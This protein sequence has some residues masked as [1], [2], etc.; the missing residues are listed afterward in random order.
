LTLRPKFPAAPSFSSHLN[1]FAMS[2]WLANTVF[3]TFDTLSTFVSPQR[4]R[5]ARP[6]AKPTTPQK[7]RAVEQGGRS[8][9]TKTARYDEDVYRSSP[10]GGAKLA[11][12]N[13]DVYHN[14]PFGSAGQER[15]DS[16][17]RGPKTPAEKGKLLIGQIGSVAEQQGAAS[18]PGKV[19][20]RRSVPSNAT[21]VPPKGTAVNKPAAG[22]HATQPP[23]TQARVDTTPTKLAHALAKQR[24]DRQM[25]IWDEFQEPE[26][27]MRDVEIRDGVWY[28]QD[29]MEK[30]GIEFFDFM[31]SMT[32]LAPDFWRIISP[33]TAKVV[34][35]VASGG[36]GG[37]QGWHDL[38]LNVGKR[39]ALATAIIGNVVVEQVFQHMFFGG[40]PEDMTAILNLQVE[41]AEADGMLTHSPALF[42]SIQTNIAAG[43]DRNMHYA[44]YIRGVVIPTRHNAF[45]LPANFDNH[46]IL[47]VGAIYTHLR[48]I[49]SMRPDT[50]RRFKNN[51]LARL[52]KLV[53][54]AG[55]LSLSMRMDMHTAYHI[56][57]VFKEDT[58]SSDRMLCLNQTEMEQT[59]PHTADTEE[60]LTE[61][62][63]LRRSRISPA[64]KTHAKGDVPLTQIV[65]MDGITAYRRGGWEIP[66]STITKLEFEKRQYAS[67]GIR[68]R[69]L[70]QGWVY[71]RWGRE[72]K[73]TQGRPAEVAA[74]HGA[75][76]GKGGFINFSQVP[77][78]V[79]WE[80]LDQ[81]S[82]VGA[83]KRA[84]PN[85]ENRNDGGSKNEMPDEGPTAGKGNSEVSPVN[86]PPTRLEKG[87]GRAKN[88][89]PENGS[90]F[91][92]RGSSSMP[93]SETFE[94]HYS[95]PKPAKHISVAELIARRKARRVRSR[96]SEEESPY[97][98]DLQDQLANDFGK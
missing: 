20:V 92:K 37:V 49:L 30:I 18:V 63:H 33:S 94:T 23:P 67:M 42:A 51:L 73:H 78:V 12:Y 22:K 65:L 1:T 27:S 71:C 46:V 97:E 26:Y 68:S 77:G 52:H 98:Q 62:E 50:S 60:G 48:P 40:M 11:R 44:N 85:K 32:S 76:W 82:R 25:A 59:N 80:E 90:P 39:K 57:P 35:C 38:F 14:S 61:A 3:S 70:T 7:R 29:L 31:P 93:I 28:L 79:N 17:V 21:S 74:H 81:G 47:I 83:K 96:S 24:G 72:R 13:E 36:P 9:G 95:P 84:T 69:E 16:G 54:I 34:A 87:K 5:P 6:R 10:S 89:T 15:V 58:F 75:A 86:K 64:E 55:V 19:N 91:N 41:H 66:D 45:R 56:E 2:S 53:T 4:L 43:F 8:G 88:V